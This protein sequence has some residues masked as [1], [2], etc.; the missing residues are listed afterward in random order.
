MVNKDVYNTEITLSTVPNYQGVLRSSWQCTVATDV[1]EKRKRVSSNPLVLDNAPQLPTGRPVVG[2]LSLSTSGLGPAD[3]GEFAHMENT[4]VLRYGNRSRIG[5]C[6]G[7]PSVIFAARY[8]CKRGLCR[9]A[10]SVRPSRS[11]ILSKRI[12]ISSKFL[13]LR[14]ATPF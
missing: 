4:I 8:I 10:A 2:Q 13:H 12:N 7:A 3:A 9:H 6:G 1:D 5:S 11:E 14:I